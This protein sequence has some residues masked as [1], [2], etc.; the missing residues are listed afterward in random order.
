MFAAS[1]VLGAFVLVSIARSVIFWLATFLNIGE[2]PVVVP[3]EQ[4]AN[5]AASR[6]ANGNRACRP[7][8]GLSRECTGVVAGCSQI[9]SR[10]RCRPTTGRIGVGLDVASGVIRRIGREA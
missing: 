3:P 2:L 4:T 10:H 7:T 6:R 8:L 9:S 1:P 5:S